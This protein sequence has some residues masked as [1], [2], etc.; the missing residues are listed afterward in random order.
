VGMTEKL[1][2]GWEATTVEKDLPEDVG[3]LNFFS[4]DS[5]EDFLEGRSYGKTF[6]L[7]LFATFMAVEMETS[8]GK[9]TLLR[10]TPKKTRSFTPADFVGGLRRIMPGRNQDIMD[11]VDLFLRPAA[12]LK[13]LYEK[14]YPYVAAAL[15]LLGGATVLYM[16][17]VLIWAA[18]QD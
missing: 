13:G 18:L 17:G 10:L 3:L 12:G 9:R 5:L 11:A 6:N 15:I 2:A 14:T 7:G 1:L 4:G 16:A 8:P